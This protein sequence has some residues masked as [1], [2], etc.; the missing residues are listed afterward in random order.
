MIKEF[1]FKKFGP[2]NDIKCSDLSNINLIIG[3]N[4]TG[5]TF[6]LKALYSIIR[7]Q[8]EYLRGDDRRDFDEVLSDKLYWTFQVDKLSDLV[9]KGS[10][11]RLEA[12]FSIEDNSSV[13]F[14]IGQDTHKKVN[15]LHNNLSKRDAN[16]IFLPP[17]EV[18]TLSKVILKSGLLDRAF[19]FDATYVD[20]VLALHN[21][22]Q[23]GRNYDT[24]K[25]SRNNLEKMF[26]GKIE[27]DT[28]QDKWVYKRGNSK[29]SIN[30]TAEGI[31]K[32]AIL[33]TLLGNRYLTP[34]S[35]IFIDEP[36][37]A[38]HPVAISELLEIIYLLSQQGIQFFIATHS[39]FVVKKLY[40]IAKKNNI[41]I[42]IF[43]S[44]EGEDWEE[45]NLK[46]G[47]PNNEIINESIRL[48][49]EELEVGLQNG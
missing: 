48:F 20:L 38:L 32:I 34:Q 15:I 14:E 46:E 11:N 2:L 23:K 40:L 49:D 37:S 21:P 19:G 44:Q 31:K 8:E 5:K 18:L 10:K 22:T 9:Q 16:S 6:F 3:S 36:E 28:K 13:V 45:S 30:T 26:K 41:D 25:T 1:S 39:Y 7:S 35:V 47:I 27:F 43:K 17:K 29:F 33:D 24:F 4:S 42:P 12:S